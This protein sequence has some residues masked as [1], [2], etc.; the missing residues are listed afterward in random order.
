MK[1]LE[2]SVT[3][4]QQ[5]SDAV[6][7]LLLE[8]GSN[9]VEMVDPEAFRQVQR[10]NAWLDY[11]DEGFL[12]QYGDDVVVRGYFQDGRDPEALRAELLAALGAMGRDGAAGNESAAGMNLPVSGSASNASTQVIVVVRDDS[13]WKDVWKDYYKP[14]E[15][16]PGFIVKPSWEEYDPKPGETILELDPGMA[17]GTGTH[18]T[19]R[20]CAEFAVA[21]TRPGDVVLDVGCGTAILGITAAKCGA[22][23]VLAIDVDDA[24]VRT[25]RENVSRN[26]VADRVEVVH[27]VL[28]DVVPLPCDVLLVNI[29]ADVIIQLAPAFRAYMA[30]DAE[31]VLSGIIRD[32]Q[33]D[34]VAAMERENFFMRAEKTMG[35]WVA[36]VFHA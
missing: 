28:D 9:G 12:D 1:W 33:A 2:V 23:R 15:L 17:F 30:P 26:A 29:I 10:D 20:M 3:T 27:G 24:A 6:S 36:M 21:V 4:T 16:A 11:T 32:R 13:E 7:D 19:T 35:E 8:L 18:E 14:F 22:S 25:A 5:M 34:V 31:I